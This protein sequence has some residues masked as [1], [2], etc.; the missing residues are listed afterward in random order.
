VTRQLNVAKLAQRRALE[1]LREKYKVEM[2]ANIKSLIAIRDSPDATAK[3][4]MEAIR[5]L[6]VWMGIP[7]A[8]ESKQAPL[9]PTA[10]EKQARSD[11]LA[12]NEEVM[13]KVKA[14]IGI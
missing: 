8:G 5:R 1:A 4:K 2:E 13:A 7:K 9:P 6:E 12:P 3:E 10:A 11:D 14:A